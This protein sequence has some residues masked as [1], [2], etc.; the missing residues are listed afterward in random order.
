ML[1]GKHCM[2]I[3]IVVGARVMITAIEPFLIYE[4]NHM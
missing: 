1:Y 2:F 3:H 4:H